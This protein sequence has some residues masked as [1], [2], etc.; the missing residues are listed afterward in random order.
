M[1]QKPRKGNYRGLKSTKVSRGTCHQGPL[2]ACSLGLSRT[3]QKTLK[4]RCFS[5]LLALQRALQKGC[6][7]AV[8]RWL[9]RTVAVRDCDSI[10]NYFKKINK[11]IGHLDMGITNP[12]LTCGPSIERRH[13]VM[14]SARSPHEAQSILYDFLV[15]TRVNRDARTSVLK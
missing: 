6:T 5:D 11:N 9:Q 12:A 10:D 7:N 2:E 1:N 14:Q 3:I 13:L 8:F 4:Q 15:I